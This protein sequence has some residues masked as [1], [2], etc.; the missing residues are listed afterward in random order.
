MG[1][2]QRGGGVQ[3]P[4]GDLLVP[5]SGEDEGQDAGLLGGAVSGGAGGEPDPAGQV[6]GGLAGG[7][8]PGQQDP[9]VLLVRG[10]GLQ[11]GGQP[12]LVAAQGGA[13]QGSGAGEEEQVGAVPV[14]VDGQGVVAFGLARQGVGAGGGAPVPVDEPVADGVPEPGQ[15]GGVQA[16][17]PPLQSV[18]EPAG[19]L[20]GPVDGAPD[21]FGQLDGRGLGGGVVGAG[22]VGVD[23]RVPRSGRH[24]DLDLHAPDRGTRL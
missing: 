2:E 24:L 14:G 17:D 9:Y 1:G 12:G 10:G 15:V 11:D 23:G 5:R 18:H 6:G 4:V 8:G 20:V 3:Q 7:G 22:P 13:G 16:A 19:L 21:L